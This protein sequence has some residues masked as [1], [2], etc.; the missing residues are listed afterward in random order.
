MTRENDR[1]RR[2]FFEQSSVAAFL[3]RSAKCKQM[4]ESG[5]EIEEAYFAIISSDRFCAM[6]F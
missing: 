4:N 3:P 2:I 5:E 1:F 6:Q